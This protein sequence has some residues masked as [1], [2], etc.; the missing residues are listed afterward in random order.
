MCRTFCCLLVTQNLLLATEHFTLHYCRGQVR[1]CAA[2]NQKSLT[3]VVWRCCACTPLTRYSTQLVCCSLW[4]SLQ[5]HTQKLILVC[6]RW[7]LV[8]FYFIHS[9]TDPQSSIAWLYLCEVLYTWFC[10]IFRW[11]VYYDFCCLNMY[12][13]D[14]VILHYYSAKSNKE[15][16]MRLATLLRHHR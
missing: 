10:S 6:V 16:A 8:F 5:V 2:N 3:C 1:L 11:W 13:R 4:S 9:R 7:R 15:F 12:T 14:N